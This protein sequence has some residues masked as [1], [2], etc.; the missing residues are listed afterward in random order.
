MEADI[1]KERVSYWISL[2]PVNRM[3]LL[4]E[5]YHQRERET[6]RNRETETERQRERKVGALSPVNHKGLHQGWKQT[7]IPSYS[8]QKSSNRIK[9][10]NPQ[11][12]R[13]TKTGRDRGEAGQRK[14]E[15]EGGGHRR[16]VSSKFVSDRIANDEGKWVEN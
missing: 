9:F 6:E 13:Q 3:G 1:Q 4:Q 11:N 8:A 5:R 16:L 14:S 12:Y 7:S 15:T 2:R 10:E